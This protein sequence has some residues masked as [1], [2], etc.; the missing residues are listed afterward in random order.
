MRISIIRTLQESTPHLL[1]PLL[2]SAIVVLAPLEHLLETRLTCTLHLR[3]LEYGLPDLATAD[4]DR[5]PREFGV[6]VE[7]AQEYP[8]APSA[9]PNTLG[10]LDKL[11][12]VV[13]YGR[14]LRQDLVRARG[15]VFHVFLELPFKA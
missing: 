11:I 3:V 12:R 9:L 13:L 6:V 1:C 4:I 14:Q 5:G 10:V 8:R 7:V 15:V 2:L